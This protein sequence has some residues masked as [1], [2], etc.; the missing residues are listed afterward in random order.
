MDGEAKLHDVAPRETAGR[1]TI[2]RYT[3]QFRAAGHACLQ[4]LEDNEI[5]FVY[6]DYHDDYVVR[7]SKDGVQTYQFHQVKTKKNKKPPM[8]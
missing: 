8:E 3:Y 7:R 2:L 4:I 1:D 5:D 6:C